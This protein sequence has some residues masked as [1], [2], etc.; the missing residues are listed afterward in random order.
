MPA[1]LKS[2]QPM[3]TNHSVCQRMSDIFIRY[4]VLAP[5]MAVGQIKCYN[6][7]VTYIHVCL[8]MNSYC[9]SIM[10]VDTDDLAITVNQIIFS[11]Q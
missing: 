1:C 2:M 8:N 7:I 11:T 5:L 10:S 6:R 9:S 4:S 3:P